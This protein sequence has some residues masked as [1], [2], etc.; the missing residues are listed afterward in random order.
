MVA[1]PSGCIA[2]REI[3]QSSKWDFKGCFQMP[4]LVFLVICI[5]QEKWQ[6]KLKLCDS[7]C[8]T[9]CNQME[10]RQL[11][12]SEEDNIYFW[13]LQKLFVCLCVFYGGLYPWPSATFPALPVP[14]WWT[15]GFLHLTGL[16]STLKK[17]VE[18]FH[19]S[20]SSYSSNVY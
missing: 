10:V 5:V 20:R 6:Q 12:N 9:P 17:K 7:E 18:G 16:S 8:E 13:K 11:L 3:K 15:P 2:Q 14:L 4:H 19:L 1:R